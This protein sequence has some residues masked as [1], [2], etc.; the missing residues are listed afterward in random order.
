MNF[1]HKIIFV[2]EV[3]KF[4]DIKS[5]KDNQSNEETLNINFSSDLQDYKKDCSADFHK[6]CYDP[7]LS[8][9]E[10]MENSPFSVYNVLACMLFERS[11][12]VKNLTQ[13][14]VDKLIFDSYEKLKDADNLSQASCILSKLIKSSKL[15]KEIVQFNND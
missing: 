7:Q 3:L 8:T 6:K 13:Y 15:H 5:E 2:N 12:N 9:H 11:C 14:D 4:S 10:Y 1:D